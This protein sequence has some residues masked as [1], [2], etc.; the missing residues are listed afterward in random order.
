MRIKNITLYISSIASKIVMVACLLMSSLDTYAQLTFASSTP[1]QNANSVSRSADIVLTFNTNTDAATVNSTNIIIAGN[2]TGII[3]GVFTGGGTAT[4]TFNPTTDFKAAEEITVSL[5]ANLTDT[6][7][8]PLTKPIYFTFVTETDANNLFKSITPPEITIDAASDIER[9]DLADID[10]DGDMDIVGVSNPDDA[11]YLYENDGNENFTKNTINT[12]ED[13]KLL[14]VVIVDLDKDGDRDIVAF[15]E[16]IVWYQNDGSGD[17][18][19]KSTLLT[20]T[21]ISSSIQSIPKIIDVDQDGDFDIVYHERTSGG[22]LNWLRNDGTQSF[23][24]NVLV[25]GVIGASEGIIF[26]MADIDGDGDI[27]FATGEDDFSGDGS[28]LSWHENDGSLG[29]TQ[30]I[31]LRETVWFTSIKIADLNDDGHLDIVYKVLVGFPIAIGWLRNDGSQSFT[32]TSIKDNNTGADIRNIDVSDLDGDGDQDVIASYNNSGI[33]L[34]FENNGSESFTEHSSS[35][36]AQFSHVIVGDLDSDGDSDIVLSSSASGVA[37]LFWHK[38]TNFGWMGGDTDWDTATN[39][40]KGAVPGASD[41]A[42]IYQ[43]TNTPTATGNITVNGMDILSG[44]ALT[45]TGTITNNGTITMESG[46]SLIAKNATGVQLTYKRNLPTNNWYLVSPPVEGSSYSDINNDNALAQGSGTNIGIGYYNDAVTNTGNKWTYIT[47][48]TLSTTRVDGWGFAVKLDAPGDLSFTGALKTGN[49]GAVA[50]PDGFYILGNPYPSYLPANSHADATNN[51]LTHNSSVLAQESLWFWDQNQAQYITINQTDPAR[52]IA[53]GQG[54]FLEI[55]SI[56]NPINFSENM[57][58]HQ[59]SD[60]FNRSSNTITRPEVRLNM[61]NGSITRHTKI[62]YISE[63]TTGFDNGYDSTLFGGADNSF[64][65]YTHLLTNDTGKPYA[66]QSL[67]DSDF[68]NMVIPVGVNADA[69]QKIDFTAQVSNLPDGLHLYLEDR[70]TQTFTRLDE[71]HS[72]YQTKVSTAL[73]GIGRFYLHTNTSKIVVNNDLNVKDIQIYT[74][75]NNNLRITG[76]QNETA[77]VNIYSI[78]GKNIFKTS[79]KGNGVNEIMTPKIAPGV[80]IVK[81]QTQKETRSK[82]IIIK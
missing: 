64:S 10:G 55:G 39:W 11:V 42:T 22:T 62:F 5:T 48:G 6:G 41:K 65:L 17:F 71:A 34:W 32:K 75:Q 15:G 61:Y 69:G 33:V 38:N 60:V 30:H 67:P 80:Y 66:I 16:K 52:Y 14:N 19:Q 13:T 27:D 47:T 51:I 24:N 77:Q 21:A 25:T 29:F 40:S 49:F 28:N 74:L 23:T 20:L 53:P 7:G 35:I 63:K 72:S 45:V 37:R 59:T 12:G 78:Q 44:A 46:S 9:F 43:T 82:K 73:Q 18:S 79:F 68:E 56:P 3:Q 58:S 70:L 26:D 54:F 81:L 2:R 57:Q 8:N 76:I 50:P 36:P 31:L 1:F 4:I